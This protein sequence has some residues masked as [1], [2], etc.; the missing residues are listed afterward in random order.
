[1]KKAKAKIEK[2]QQ[3]KKDVDGIVDF[4]F[5][6]GML[7]KTPRSGFFFLGSGDQTVAEHLNRVAYIGYS[8]AKMAKGVDVGKVV[9]MCIFHDISESRIS[10][11]NYVHQKYTTRLEDKAHSDLAETLVFG[12]D[13]KLLLDE[14]EERKTIEAIITKDAD[15]IEFLLC[16]KEQKDIGNR[17]AETWIPSLIKRIKTKEGKIL[18]KSIMKADS[19][20]WW[21][22]DKKDKWWVNRGK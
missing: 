2:K 9:Q 16:L 13:M 5:E 10:D 17:R 20:R 15:N 4:L 6:A 18:A 11:L 21:F 7:A 22:G 8:L 12:G 14:Y 1:M 3:N 19:D